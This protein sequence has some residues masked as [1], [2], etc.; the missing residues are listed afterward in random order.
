VLGNDTDVDGDPLTVTAATSPNGTVV[1]NPDGTITF[2]PNANF[3]GPTTITYTISDGR[4]G[5]STATV[6]VTVTPVNDPPVANNDSAATPE[7][8][9]VTINLLGNDTDFDGDPLTVTAA[10][11]PNGAVVINA[12]GTITFTPNAN[13]NGPTTITYTISDGRGGTSTAT[14]N[15]TVTPVNDPPVATND[16]ATTPEDAPVTINVLGNDADV[17]GDPLTITA[18]T[19]PNGTVV[20][21]PDGTTTFTPNANFNG[22]TT[23]TYTISDGRGGTSTATVNVTVTP[24]NDPPVAVNDT[25]VTP[26]DTPVRINPLTNDSD[27]DGNP[28]TITAARAANGTVVVNADGSTT[29]TPNP[30]FNGTDTITYTISD[31]QGGF[32]TA[33]ITVNVA[34]VNDPPIARNDVAI[35]DADTPVRISVLGNDNDIDGDPLT[36]TAASSPNG[37]IVRNADGTITFTPTAGFVGATTITY[38]ISD[39]K[40]GT[41]T[42]TVAVTVRPTNT[43]PV[44]GNEA[45]STIGGVENTIPVLANA[46]DADGNPLSVFSAVADVGTVIINPDGTLKYTAPF[47]FQGIARIT[48]VVS[49]GKGGFVT[50]TVTIDVQQANADMNALIDGSNALAIPDRAVTAPLSPSDMGF[51]SATPYV[52]NAVNEFRSLGGTPDLGGHR[53]LLTAINGI[54]W[55]KGTADLDESD[56][57]IDGVVNQID[58]IRDLRFGADRLF[59][60]RFGDFILKSL[61]GFSVRQIHTGN[62]QIMIESVVRDRV[63]YMEVRDIGKDGDPR[64]VEYQLRTRNGGALPEWIT[65]DKRGLAIM[66]RPVDAETLHLIVR[67]IRADG[68]VFDIPVLVQGATGEIQLDDAL[69]QKISAVGTLNKNLAMA[70]NSA[71]DETAQLAAAFGEKT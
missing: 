68:K 35:T 55:L 13:F 56:G 71:A 27:I 64:I 28:L 47:G 17:D 59:D 61:T 44:D 39:G 26:E 42:A 45:I 66:E 8:T 25:A 50:S 3:N 24:V 36:I 21:N 4:G 63:V 46:R 34:P 49:D 48:Y 22:A 11:S 52:I 5:T 12:D 70:A 51:I 58:R 9:P 32:S 15:V 1:I 14:V 69:T 16:T 41:S 23:I 20:I 67:A 43:P 54:S 53:P 10:T 38:T 31:G 40:G 2:T 62:D 65:M 37:T 29:Y 19:S 60:H 18:A 57:A 30:N 7:D 6:N 33:T